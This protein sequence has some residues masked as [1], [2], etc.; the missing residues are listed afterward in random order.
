MD[1]IM[2]GVDAFAAV[3]DRLDP[4]SSQIPSSLSL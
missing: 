4:F 3:A 2:N 1:C